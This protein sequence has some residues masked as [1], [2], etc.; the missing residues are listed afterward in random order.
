MKRL[1]SPRHSGWLPRSE[2]GRVEPSERPAA[3][4]RAERADCRGMRVE[5]REVNNKE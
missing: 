5:S 2:A 3:R 4:D 1:I